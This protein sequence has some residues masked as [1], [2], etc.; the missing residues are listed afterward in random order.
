MAVQTK[1]KN[2]MLPIAAGAMFALGF[3]CRVLMGNLTRIPFLLLAVSYVLFAV[4]LFVR[5]K[6]AL[7]LAPIALELVS[8]FWIYGAIYGGIHLYYFLDFA[9][10]VSFFIIALLNL[11]GKAKALWF[12]PGIFAALSAVN[13]LLNVLRIIPII[14]SNGDFPVLPRILVGNIVEPLLYVVGI[15]LAAKW[16]AGS[17]TERKAAY[18]GAGAEENAPAYAPQ[19]ADGYCSIAVHILLL[20]FTCGIYNL[21]WIYRTTKYLNCIEGDQPRNA[22]NK[23]LLCLFVPFYSIYWTYQSA[24]QIDKLAKTKGRASDL[25]TLCLI[26]ALLVPIV[27]P[28]LMQSKINEIVGVPD[29]SASAPAY[30]PASTADY[31][32][33][34]SGNTNIGAAD[35]LKKY[36]EL[37]DSGVISQEEF[38]TKKE[39][40]LGL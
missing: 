27:P 2:S 26:M 32:A 6:N 38:D 11:Q 30:A 8:K 35:E 3:L 19:P 22:T 17:E 37:L 13:S 15:L 20:L 1:D 29:G 34:P 14:L 33:A 40:L 9:C 12:L 4:V 36:K 21:V 7:I 5:Q 31:T 18:P 24:Q 16:L 28:I 39:Q 10:L 23:L 25:A